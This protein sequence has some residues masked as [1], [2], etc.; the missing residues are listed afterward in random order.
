MKKKRLGVFNHIRQEFGITQDVYANCGNVSRELVKRVENSGGFI[1]A[2]FP[3]ENLLIMARSGN[4]KSP[5]A[6]CAYEVEEKA[7]INFVN[8]QILRLRRMHAVLQFD[9]SEMVDT[10]NNTARILS[11]LNY[12]LANEAAMDEF[13]LN[14][15]RGSEIRH[16]RKYLLSLPVKQEMI[17]LEIEIIEKK[18]QMLEGLE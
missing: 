2:L 1:H 6:A 10:Y 18:L 8:S 15:M 5:S 9:L 16:R 7:S 13:T 11:N 14:Q 4:T 17:K 3:L 12:L